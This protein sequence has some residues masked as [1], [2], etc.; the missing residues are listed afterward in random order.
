MLTLLDGHFRTQKSH[1]KNVSYNMFLDT[2]DNIEFGRIFRLFHEFL[3]DTLYLVS[4]RIHEIQEKE[5]LNVSYK[6]LMKE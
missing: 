6:S 4:F 3:S 2:N 1:K 5:N